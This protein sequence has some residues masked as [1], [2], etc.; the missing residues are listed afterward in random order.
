MQ[1]FDSLAKTLHPHYNRFDVANRLLFTGHSHQAWPDAAF[2][3][4]QEYMDM[5]TEQVDKKWGPSFEKTEIMRNYLRDFYD[6]PNGKYCREQN[7]HVLIVS[8]LSAL[9]LKNKPKIITTTGEF[10]SMYRQLKSLESAGIEVVYL[11]HQDDEKLL[12]LIKDELNDRT[13][14]VMLSRVYFE[15]SEINTRLPEIADATKKAGVPLMIDDYHG[16][17]VVPISFKKEQL[18]HVYLLIGGYKYLQWGE[19]NCFLRYPAD[20]NLKPVIT[21]WF[22]AFEQLDHPRTDGPV[23]FDDGD[24]KFATAT[25]DPISQFRG[26]A[27]TQFFQKMGLTPEVLRNSYSSQLTYLRFLFDEYNFEGSQIKH[28]NIRPVEESGGFLA[29]RSP[30]ARNLRAA[31]LENGIFTDARDEIIRLGPAPYTT[32]KQCEKVITALFDVLKELQK[33]V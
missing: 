25:Y 5:V 21:G 12:D 27:V 13:A 6:D 32:S 7:T 14:A 31:L 3:G 33:K 23:Q 15:T 8:W 24:Q 28:A 4:V 20:C 17:N 9:D 22:S 29:L 2:D 18:E 26:A 11:P 30:L 16:T 19:A 10:H 1:E